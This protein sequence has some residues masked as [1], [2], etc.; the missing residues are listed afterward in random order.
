MAERYGDCHTPFSYMPEMLELTAL[1]LF[2][3]DTSRCHPYTRYAIRGARTA[4][5]HVLQSLDE[6]FSPR[7][8]GAAMEELLHS[9]SYSTV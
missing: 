9:A 1:F 8:V 5:R 3:M 7:E 6:S 2:S 4:A